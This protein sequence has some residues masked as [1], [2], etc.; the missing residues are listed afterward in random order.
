MEPAGETSNLCSG[1]GKSAFKN[2]VL[3]QISTEDTAIEM[4]IEIVFQSEGSA[5]FDF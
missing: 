2:H 4:G 1:F 3:T 5:L